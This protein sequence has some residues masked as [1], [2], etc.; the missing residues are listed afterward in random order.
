MYGVNADRDQVAMLP[1]RRILLQ[2]SVDLR[3]QMCDHRAVFLAL[4]IHKRDQHRL[5]LIIRQRRRL[6]ALVRHRNPRNTLAH[7]QRMRRQFRHRQR[8]RRLRGHHNVG[9]VPGAAIRRNQ[10][11]ALNFVAGLEPVKDL[12]VFERVHHVGRRQ[13]SRNHTLLD[14]HLVRDLAFAQHP[15]RHRI[16]RH[17]Q[18][19]AHR[20]GLLKAGRMAQLVASGGE[21]HQQSAQGGCANAQQTR[22]AHA[23]SPLGANLWGLPAEGPRGIFLPTQG[24]TNIVGRIAQPR[25]IA[26]FAAR[27]FPAGKKRRNLLPFSIKAPDPGPPRC[28]T[29]PQPV[30]FSCYGNPSAAQPIRPSVESAAQA[31]RHHRR[32]R[33]LSLRARSMALSSHPHPAMD[34]AAPHDCRPHLSRYRAHPHASAKPPQLVGA[35]DASALKRGRE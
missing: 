18:A 29:L 28:D 22:T 23:R 19:S 26:S 31:H 10:H 6:A 32:A 7:Q 8:V 33:G 1:R 9:Q 25:G 21:Y 14:H 4:R 5:A 15:A 3:K 34:L 30:H 17:I 24:R 2:Q 35:A 13:E 20:A 11:I 27:A 16:A 12:A